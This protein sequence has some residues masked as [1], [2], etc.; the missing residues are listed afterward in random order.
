MNNKELA[1]ILG[2]LNKHHLSFGSTYCSL[3]CEVVAATTQTE[4]LVEPSSNVELV[5]GGGK[6]TFLKHTAYLVSTGRFENNRFVGC[7]YIP[8]YNSE[9]NLTDQI[10]KEY[11]ISPEKAVKFVSEIGALHA[12]EILWL[13][14]DAED[15]NFPPLMKEVFVVKSKRNTEDCRQFRRRN[16]RDLTQ[17]G[18]RKFVYDQFGCVSDHKR[19]LT[20][21]MILKRYDAL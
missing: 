15:F 21:L 1:Q 7:V 11:A 20:L 5:G 17:E 9:Q 18:K 2:C 14:D 13:L 3:D 12:N 8:N 16:L 4:Q 6:T 10:S 19:A